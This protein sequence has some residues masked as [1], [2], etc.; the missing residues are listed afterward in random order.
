MISINA[1]QLKVSLDKIKARKD[2]IHKTADGRFRQKL[3]YLFGLAV[4]VSPQFSGDFAANWNIVVD[5]NMPVYR[6]LP[7]KYSDLVHEKGG[8][9]R[10]VAH[11]AGDPE[12]VNISTFRGLGQL[13]G[14]TLKSRVHFVNATE[15]HTD[16]TRMIGPDGAVNLRPENLI[17]G[18]VRIE[19]YLR[20][21]AKEMA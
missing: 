11:K 19:S 17:P 8:H 10:V 12:A 1:N 15:L 13:K 18:G 4:K 9:Y 3:L 16:G 2:Q 20:A 7:G 14:V 6:P 21:R 5:G